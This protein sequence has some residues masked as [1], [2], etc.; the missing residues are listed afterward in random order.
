MKLVAHEAETEALTEWLRG[1]PLRITS[2]LS[3]VELMR[4]ARRVAAAADDPTVTARAAAVLTTLAIASLS[5][6][7]AERAGVV[8]PPTLRSLDAVHLATALLA[9]PLEALVAYD[10][11]LADAARAA[12]ISVVQPG[13]ENV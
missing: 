4:A 13:R 2:L 9:G 12:G 8:D 7:T 3:K 1:R 5:D 10:Q 6:A 11:R